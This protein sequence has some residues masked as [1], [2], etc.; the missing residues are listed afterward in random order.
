MSAFSRRTLSHRPAL[1]DRVR[2]G[3]R[4]EPSKLPLVIVFAAAIGTFPLAYGLDALLGIG[5]LGS[6]FAAL[7][8]AA[9]LAA[10]ACATIR[11]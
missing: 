7:M 10:S 5:W 11:A 4:P 1:A 9:T 2:P 8:I 3:N 6:A